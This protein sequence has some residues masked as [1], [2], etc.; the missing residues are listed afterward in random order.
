MK[1]I[2]IVSGGMD[3][4]VLATHL[5]ERKYEQHLLSFNYGQR[6][7]KELEY[8]F[9]LSAKLACQ[10]DVVDLTSL[11]RLLAGSALT[12]NI[13]VPDGHY[14]DESMK[15]TIV[16][17]RNA[18]MLSIAYA[19]AVAENASYVAYG[20]HAGDHAIY[21]DCRPSFVERFQAMEHV[22]AGSTILLKTPFLYLTKADI[23]KEGHRLGVDFAATWSCYKGGEIH[24]GT[25]GTCVERREAF[26]LAGVEDPT[27]YQVVEDVHS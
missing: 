27:T 12:D 26:H 4:A 19:V 16:P 1:V 24:C 23:V 25:C 11:K 15:A 9:Y 3:S 21:P 22:A 8:A 10:Y 14:T 17:N 6:H 20:A 7:V 13:V 5:A 18:I 2:T